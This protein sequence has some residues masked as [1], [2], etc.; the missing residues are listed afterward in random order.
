MATPAS[1]ASAAVRTITHWIDGKTWEGP[2]ARWG[3]V[4]DP[5]TGDLAARVAFADAAVV[6]AAVRAATRAFAAWR[7]TSLAARA[8][9]L[10]AYREL[11]ERHRDALA[12][13]VTRE[14][15][16]VL[17]DA[18]G[19]VA[20]GLEVVEFACGLADLLKGEFSEN[21]S[22]DVD[23]HSIRQPL[24]VVVGITPFNFPV[25]VPMWMYPLA[26]ACGNAFILKPSE[27][28]PSASVYCARL[29]AEAGVPEGVF[30]VVHGDSATVEALV[31][32]PGVA[33]V[34]FV[35][36]TPV[37]RR[38][39]ELAARAGTRVQALGGAKNHLVVLPDADLEVAADAAVGA[40]Y[41]SSGQRCMA[42]SVVVAV[43]EIGDALV[44]RLAERVRRLRVGPGLDPSA[45]MGPLVTSAHRAR[46]VQYVERGLAEG[47]TLVVDG[48][49]L[50]ID[51][52]ER[53]FFLG[54]CLFDHVTP[55]MTI[56]RDEIFGPVLSVV[57]VPRFADAV[58]LVNENPW[59]NGAA[60]FTNDGG[61]ARRFQHE[62]TVGMVG[63]NVPIPVPTAAY[64]FGGWKQ[65][66][67]GDAHMHGREGV[68][69]Y[70]RL[71]VVTTRWPDARERGVKLGFPQTR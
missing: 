20:R 16:K 40:A 33:A 30:N 57:R 55:E 1:E 2:V 21:V 13:L 10:F 19:E 65:S 46:V 58:S 60:I 52:H 54:P 28:D 25:M 51:G 27:K 22:T 17:A 5:A 66:L 43:G 35:G 6:D 4:F 48:R 7:E 67:F 29:L 45:E 37:A 41:G 34:S 31:T 11:V 64:A 53:G 38:V 12:E 23:A 14:H 36:S 32:H 62:V 59:G 39:F 26:L 44:A 68:R 24:G 56:Y 3:D 9:V 70:T 71:K 63:I 61:A 50:R 49:A 69:F 15:G 47:A 8:R 18:R 42:V